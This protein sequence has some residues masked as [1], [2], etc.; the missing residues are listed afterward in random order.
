[1]EDFIKFD[2]EKIRADADAILLKAKTSSF[3]KDSEL[4]KSLD[5]IIDNH[6]SGLQEVTC[7]SHNT[8]EKSFY[9]NQKDQIL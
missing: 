2:L 5:I 9:I 8:Q 4:D 6:N 7:F 1:M 3:E